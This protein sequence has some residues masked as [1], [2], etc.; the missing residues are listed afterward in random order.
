LR[1]AGSLLLETLRTLCSEYGAVLIFDEVM[2]G[3]RVALGGAQALYGIEPDL[4]TLAKL[5][6]A[7]CRSALSAASA[8]SWNRLHRSDR[9][10]RQA[11]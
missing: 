4:T 11:L 10:T 3:F 9:C 8:R 5:S 1:A 6:A 2:T 7:A